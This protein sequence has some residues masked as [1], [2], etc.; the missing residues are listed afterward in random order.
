MR[1][2]SKLPESL[3]HCKPQQDNLQHLHQSKGAYL[4][5]LLYHWEMWQLPYHGSFR[6]PKTVHELQNKRL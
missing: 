6:E 2:V 5:L 4:V 1:F 3:S